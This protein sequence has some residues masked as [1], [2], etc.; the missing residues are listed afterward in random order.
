MSGAARC[1]PAAPRVA[2]GPAGLP[3]GLGATA[4]TVG[5]F[6]GVHLGHQ[7]L[8]ARVVVAAAAGGLEP[9]AVTFDR[10][11]VEVLRPGSHPRRLT[12][13]RRRVALLGRHGMRLVLVL[14]FTAELS[15]VPA[16]RFATEVLF[17]ALG[18]RAV[19]VGENFRFGHRAAGDPALLAA[20]G[21][22]RGVALH[23]VGL[24]G[25]GEGDR[26]P[27]PGVYA[28]HA[29]LGEGPPRPAVSSV[30]VNPQFGGGPR[31]ESHLLDYD[32]D[33]YGRRLAVS[34]E[35]RVSDNAAF[36]SVEALLAKM[37]ADVRRARRLLAAAPDP[38]M[39]P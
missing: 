8:L 37:R 23:T 35:H 36:P 27:A 28:G 12:T 10:H 3:A 5:M 24:L 26:L 30:G 2:L 38:G 34:F 32:G 1:D 21:G 4:V 25:G 16:E 6:D 11:P 17:D 15:R 14:P 9:A 7:A 39:L 29:D 33:L 18:A 13:L 19:V 22:P 31:V 20:L